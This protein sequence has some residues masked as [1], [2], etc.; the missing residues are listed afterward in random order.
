MTGFTTALAVEARKA[1]ASTTLR[2]TGLLLAI[3]VP[4]IVAAI[5]AAARG[6][7][8]PQARAQL[9]A[10]LGPEISA[11]DW[12]ALVVASTQ[13]TAAA[14]VFAFGT[15]AAWIFGREFADGTAPALF[16]LPVSRPAIAAAKIV[17]HLCWSLLVCLVLAV[18]LAVA[19]LAVGLG[20]PGGE[21][22][23]GL[24]RIVA[25]GAFTALIALAAAVA[26]TLGRGVLP[27]IAVAAI[28][29]VAA[30]ISVFA[31]G[32]AWVPLATPALWAMHPGTVPAG[33]LALVVGL[34]ALCAALTI[35]AWHHLRLAR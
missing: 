31:G 16:G 12:H 10:K 25:L 29:I 27:G 18:A 34:G 26:A 3:G 11:A 21:V 22:A 2:A 15:G 20:R 13:V 5:L 8:T 32:S 30:Q 33:A 17:V 28:T 23:D 7:G 24:A 1:V 9:L 14:A 6:G 19:G 4:A 35:D